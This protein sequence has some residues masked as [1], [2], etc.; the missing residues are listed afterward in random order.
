MTHIDATAALRTAL[1]DAMESLRE[2]RDTR[3]GDVR[4][5]FLVHDTMRLIAKNS[6]WRI[7]QVINQIH[8]KKSM[9]DDV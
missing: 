4:T 9:N 3:Y 6:L 8:S 1:D 5:R 2:I 7:E